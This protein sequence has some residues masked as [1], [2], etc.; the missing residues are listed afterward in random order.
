MHAANSAFARLQDASWSSNL[1]TS[2]APPTPELESLLLQGAVNVLAAAAILVLGWVAA[3]S[4]ARWIRTGLGRISHFDQTLTPLIASLVR[5]AIL[6]VSL[7]AVME[8]F[9]V[10]TTSMIAVLGAAGL[11]VGLA[12]QGTL[13]NVA[14]G[15]MLLLLRP[16]RVGENVQAAGRSGTVREIGLFTTI[17]IADDLSFV[18]IPNSAIFSGV[19]VNNSREPFKLIN[20]TVSIDFSNDVEEAQ[21]IILDVL[22]SDSRVLRAPPPATG[23]VALHEYAVD[24][25]VRCTVAN[26]DQERVLFAIQR[27]IKNRFH[28]A[29]IA[30]PARRQASTQRAEP[31]ING[32]KAATGHVTH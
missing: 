19:I 10:A 32:A 14:A 29:G 1:M 31:T 3:Q 15:V 7:V 20:I 17:M 5:Y 11:A 6:I 30:I 24:L 23:I 21:N 16:F 28:E 26:A 9:G 27:E 4:A 25:L 2:H 8:R 13:S 18:S 12:L 22:K